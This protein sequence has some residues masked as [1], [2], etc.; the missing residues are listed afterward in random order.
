[1]KLCVSPPPHTNMEI[2]IINPLCKCVGGGLAKPYLVITLHYRQETS[3]SPCSPKHHIV[4][5]IVWLTAIGQPNQT[6]FTSPQPLKSHQFEINVP[7][8]SHYGQLN[9]IQCARRNPGTTHAYRVNGFGPFHI[10]AERLHCI[11]PGRSIM[12]GQVSMHTQ[13]TH[14]L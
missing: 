12:L 9:A 1:M 7:A 2:S 11:Q 6:A 3:I 8:I 10:A 13:H 14:T 4:R 5:L